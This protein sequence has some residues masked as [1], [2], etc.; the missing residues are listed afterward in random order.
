M[1]SIADGIK[2]QKIYSFGMKQSEIQC[3]GC[4]LHLGFSFDENTESER[5]CLLS[6]CLDFE[7]KDNSIDLPN[8]TSEPKAILDHFEQQ[9]QTA[10]KLIA[11]GEGIELSERKPPTV[12]PEEPPTLNRLD[13]PQ[14]PLETKSPKTAQAKNP[15]KQAPKKASSAGT[16][17]RGIPTTST[18]NFSPE[19][20]KPRSEGS[21]SP[22]PDAASVRLIVAPIV[23]TIVG[24]VLIYFV[25]KSA[26]EKK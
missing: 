16:Q 22:S 24:S 6:L 7:A 4:S 20:R 2:I 23:L 17:S 18:G 9:E 11:S 8:F 13:T 1:G 26:Q 3:G 5:H 14:L 10:I 25:Y 21:A 19:T 12:E 15:H